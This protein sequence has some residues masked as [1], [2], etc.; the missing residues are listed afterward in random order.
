MSGERSIRKPLGDVS[1][2]V[3]KP[4]LRVNFSNVRSVQ[5]Y[6]VDQGKLH[7]GPKTEHFNSS[8]GK[9]KSKETPKLTSSLG[10]QSS[11]TPKDETNTDTD[12]FFGD[13]KRKSQS[14]EMIKTE[15][16][17]HS[18]D[19]KKHVDSLAGL[20]SFEEK[21]V[22]ET[23]AAATPSMHKICLEH[24]EQKSFIPVRDNTIQED[25]SQ[26]LPLKSETPSHAFPQSAAKDHCK[27]LQKGATLTQ[28]FTLNGSICSND[29]MDFIQEE[30]S[31]ISPA[32]IS[33]ELNQS[34]EMVNECDEQVHSEV[35]NYP[36]K[37]KIKEADSLYGMKN[38]SISSESITI[39]LGESAAKLKELED[40]VANRRTTMGFKQI[41]AQVKLN[42][43]VPQEEPSNVKSSNCPPLKQCRYKANESPRNTSIAI[44]T[45]LQRTPT[46]NVSKYQK[47]KPSNNLQALSDTLTPRRQ[48]SHAEIGMMTPAQTCNTAMPDSDP[49]CYPVQLKSLEDLKWA[50]KLSHDP[51]WLDEVKV[52]R[53]IPLADSHFDLHG[54][55]AGMEKDE[56]RLKVEE[57][58]IQAINEFE[59]KMDFV[60]KHI[61]AQGTQIMEQAKPFKKKMLELKEEHDKLIEHHNKRVDDYN[62]LVE[63]AREKRHAENEQFIHDIKQRVK[64]TMEEWETAN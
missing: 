48:A 29:G 51:N 17:S 8:G 32:K 35:H 54:P 19:Q 2:D 60:R 59:G 15:I 38:L 39:K 18:H 27:T 16:A 55:T 40:K 61:F 45:A 23:M 3:N 46:P 33:E 49:M 31:Q 43:T 4:T 52:P 21:E 47:S 37:P 53:W 1:G 28:V 36:A 14:H 41:L 64:A 20:L 13:M 25:K 62:H 9:A 12:E 26:I 10:A 5:Q 56:L 42:R 7:G 24:T 30:N 63:I 11:K 44:P 22:R 50:Q 6:D 57:I 58:V 34:V